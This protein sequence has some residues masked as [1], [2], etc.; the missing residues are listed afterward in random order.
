[1]TPEQISNSIRYVLP[2]VPDVCSYTT[3][4]KMNCQSSTCSTTGTGFI[5][6]K[7]LLFSIPTLLTYACGGHSKHCS[8]SYLRRSFVSVSDIILLSLYEFD[9]NHVNDCL[10]CG[11]SCMVFYK[12]EELR[13]RYDAKVQSVFLLRVSVLTH[14]IDIGILSVHSSVTFQY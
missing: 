11:I 7:L 8:D 2:T 9:V 12:V 13:S 5:S 6:T 3:L 1:M 10:S 14:N 4:V